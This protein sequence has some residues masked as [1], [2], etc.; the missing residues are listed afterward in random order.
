MRFTLAGLLV[1]PLVSLVAL[2]GFAA[3]ITLSNALHE[4]NYNRLIALSS[5][6]TDNLVNQVSQERLQTFAW[7]STDPRPSGVQLTASRNRTDAAVSA[8]HRMLRQTGG[9]RPSSER[10]AQATLVRLLSRLPT[11]RASVDAETLSA[12]TAFQAYSNIMDAV[13]AVYSAS[14]Q[15]NSNLSVDRQTDASMDAAQ[16][17]EYASRESALVGGAA[18]AHGQ[19]T[20]SERQ[21]FA[22][23]VANQRLLM[24]SALGDFDPQLG[25][26]W[27]RIYNS[28]LHHQ[29][30][31]LENRI[32][33]SI[34]SRGAIPVNIQTWQAVSRAFL[35]ELEKAQIQDGPPLA[36]MASR[37][38]NQLVLEAA[39]AGG[40][41][42][43][44]VLLSIFVLLRYGR[45]L[46]GELTN[47]HDTAQSMAGRR[48]P[49]VVE[50]L[51]KGEEVDV[52]A[53][54][55]PPPPGRITEIAR[56]A[57]SFATVQRTAVQAAVG[58]ANLRKSVNQVF[59]NLSLRNQ[60]LLHRQ[61]GML[62][63]ME[64]ATSAPAVLADLFRLD[65]L[66]TRMRRHA[67]GLIILS[68]A[69]PGRGWREP[70]PVVDVLRAAIAE[71]EDYVRVDVATDSRDAVAGPAV[72]DMIHLAAELIENATTFS[73]PATRVEI[74]ADA[75]GTG[76]AVEIEDRGLG[77]SGPELDDINQ[78]LAS[79]PEFDL[80]NSDQLGLFVVGQ[81]AARHGIR[82]SLRGSPFGGTTAIVLMPYSIIVR[83]AEPAQ[84]GA[85][86][87]PAP[88][89]A[90]TG[91]FLAGPADPAPNPRRT[92]LFG[93]T[94]RQQPGSVTPPAGPDPGLP[95]GQPSWTPPA[96]AAPGG[97]AAGPPLAPELPR[98]DP[99]PA[100]THRG[101]P[102]RVRQ[103]HLAPQLRGS[104][105]NGPLAAAR[106][107]ADTTGRSPEENRDLMS[108]L[109]QGW[110]RGRLDDLDDPA[111]G[112]EG[113]PGE[114]PAAAADPTDGEAS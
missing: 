87:G 21:L 47:L 86:P 56:V 112:V 72:N 30:A 50:R 100:G 101:L 61:L 24:D 109:Q 75:V 113:W 74:R 53:E 114:R 78:R 93:V 84:A 39:L 14:E 40:V 110:Q 27:Q 43:L 33:G 95:G 70:V 37:L 1:V 3:S 45:R 46:N 20:T 7:L 69:T 31:A 102:R 13:F 25:A 62:D 59:L 79:P 90:G 58:Q 83:A 28:P 41:G 52:D 66:T 44:A 57:R 26:P 12:A 97:P 98:R 89:R 6:P 60:S 4:H 67:E 81:L 22:N 11:I 42:L 36:A 88:A 29:F 34:G 19:M 106:P 16:A 38:S 48:L 9:L 111:D 104:A 35:G 82:V 91:A 99:A 96:P 77:L 103:A 80:A 23:A 64:R 51:R 55:P 2:W 65:H 76:F 108:A 10:P 18:G 8:Y 32:A 63:S 54:S 15:V 107:A 94:G 92:S 105:G 68:G 49:D 17:L 5:A 73:P 85:S 71:V